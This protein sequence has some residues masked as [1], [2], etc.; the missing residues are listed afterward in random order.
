MSEKQKQ[1]E[2]ERKGVV[3]RHFA[4]MTPDL[5][6]GLQGYKPVRNRTVITENDRVNN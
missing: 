2:K 6:S 1:V 3:E 5:L 4:E